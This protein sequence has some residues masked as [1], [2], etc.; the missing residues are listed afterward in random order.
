MRAIGYISTTASMQL[1]DT[2]QY[3][4]QR[5]AI[6]AYCN[7]NDHNL[8]QIFHDSSQQAVNRPEYSKLLE[9]IDTPKQASLVVITDCGSLGNSLD[10]AIEAILRIDN[11]GSTVICSSPEY[12]DPIQNALNLFRRERSDQVRGAMLEKALKGEALGRTPFGYRI[13]TERS[14]EPDPLESSIVARIFDMYIREE[15]GFRR[16]VNSLNDSSTLNR[17]NAQWTIAQI[18]GVLRNPVYIGTYRRFGLRIPSNHEPIVSTTD[19]TNA[20]QLMRSKRT[21]KSKRKEQIYPLSGLLLCMHCNGRMIGFSRR[22]T[23]RRK[24]GSRNHNV[25]RYY[26]CPQRLENPLCRANVTSAGQWEAIA[27]KCL[28]VYLT[29]RQEA[30]LAPLNAPS[31]PLVDTQGSNTSDQPHLGANLQRRWLKALRLTAA[32]NLA[33]GDLRRITKELRY[34]NSGVDTEIYVSLNALLQ[35]GDIEVW[36]GMSPI[37]QKALFTSLITHI[38]VKPSSASI[39]LHDG[40]ELVVSF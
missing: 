11:A 22:Q 1:D 29:D 20:Q 31:M 25:Y 33:L 32:G 18:L 17:N 10:E 30:Y 21:F 39:N 24:D 36:N 19:F 34:L 13:N 7:Y 14:L 28:F 5:E 27:S 26:Y 8:V 15:I 38:C 40:D 35:R 6:L 16:I 2:H 4:E 37:H 9:F 3:L 12:P 23:W